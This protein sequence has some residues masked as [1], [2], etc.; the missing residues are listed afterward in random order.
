LSGGNLNDQALAAWDSLAHW[1]GEAMGEGD[2]FHRNLVFPALKAMVAANGTPSRVLDLACGT[3]QSTRFLAKLVSEVIAVDFSKKMLEEARRLSPGIGN[4][5]YRQADLTEHR[6][7]MDIAKEK[8]DAAVLSMAAHDIADLHPIAK[9][10]RVIGSVRSLML[11][12][13]HPCF[14]SPR[15]STFSEKYVGENWK[16]LRGVRV[17]DYALEYC[18]LSRVKDGQPLPQLVFHRS[19]AQ[20]LKPFTDHGFVVAALSEPTSSEQRV[21]DIPLLMAINLIRL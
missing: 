5:R 18:D 13:P 4:I 8:P 14:N 3:G 12:T 6:E 20:L 19:L 16:E 15:A 9:G 17:V 1:W 10:L 7:W 11:V 21:P 2:S